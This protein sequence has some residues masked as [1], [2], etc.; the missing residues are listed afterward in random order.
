MKKYIKENAVF[1]EEKTKGGSIINRYYSPI[2]HMKV[3]IHDTR[4]NVSVYDYLENQN[5][6]YLGDVIVLIDGQE[7]S[8]ETL[9]N[10][11][12]SFDMKGSEIGVYDLV[13]RCE[14]LEDC[15]VKYEAY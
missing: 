14:G 9:I 6:D 8:R 5:I 15:E 2:N 1:V 12:V 3:E 10:G 4:I 13:F 7:V 11:F